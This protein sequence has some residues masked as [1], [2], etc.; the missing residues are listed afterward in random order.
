MTPKPVSLVR[1]A[2][3]S[4]AAS[5]L[6]I[7]LKALAWWIT[8][9][10]GLLADALESG[11]NLAAACAAVVALQVAAQPADEGHPYGHGKAEYFSS[12]LEGAL[13]LVAAAA[14]AVTAV[15][16]LLHP[17]PLQDIGV[18]LAVSVVA[19]AINFA[20][21]RVLLR[22]GVR[23]HSIALEAD[24]R[25][26]MTDVW[27]SVGVVVGVGAVAMTGL[28]WLDPVIALAVALNIVVTGYVL[29]R[30]SA[31]GLMDAA[32]PDADQATI[33]AIL[34]GYRDAGI[35]YHALRTRQAGA[36]RFIELHLLVPGAWTVQHGHDVMERIE[37]QLREQI[38][39]ATMS[40][41]LE[42]IED[43]ASWDDIALDRSDP[44]S[45][46]R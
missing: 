13:I 24:G 22:A 45:S 26:L 30:R 9:S 34:D 18:G 36:R 43:S 14:I 39:N 35:D 37:A 23:Y 33:R 25:H 27:T 11:V 16:R 15:D 20:V 46:E 44:H 32:L 38:P 28:P 42:P 4:V 19:T 3:L 21:A 2:W 41:H 12:W 29:V 1:Y 6:V 40:I 10:V 31:H 8:G 7:A 5:I 17:R